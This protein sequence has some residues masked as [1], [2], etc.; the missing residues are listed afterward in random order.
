M[1]AIVWLASYP[2]SGNTWMRAFLHNLLV[3]PGKPADINELDKFCLGEDKALYYNHFDPKPCSEMTADEIATLRPKVHDLLT[4]SF[5]DSVFVKTHNFM[6]S[7]ADVPLV[8]MECTAGAIYIVRNPLDLVLSY[9]HHY[10]YTID[11]AIRSLADF[12]AG[13][14]TTDMNVRQNFSTWSNHVMSW[15]QTPLPG[16]H[17]VRY[18]DLLS[19][20]FKTF[21]KVVK[22][23]G[24]DARRERLQRAIANS[25]FKVLRKQEDEHG[26]VERSQHARF[27]RVGQ[28]GQW[29][30]N[31]SPEQIAAIVSTHREQMTRFGYVPKGY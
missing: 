30:K 4:Q 24:L 3:N 23:L 22:F 18:E 13:T 8:T 9:S 31:L 7:A 27:F 14:V 29:R 28:A 11:E 10:G 1:G 2:K 17:L 5:P 25:S 16:L 6:G 20:P 21:A 19:K 26:F 12:G 15:T